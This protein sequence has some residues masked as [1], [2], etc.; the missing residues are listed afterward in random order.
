MH[1]SQMAAME[2][3]AKAIEACRNDRAVAAS[4]ANCRSGDGSG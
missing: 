4:V 1:P 2:H 3:E